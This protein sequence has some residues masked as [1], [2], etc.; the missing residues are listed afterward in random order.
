MKNVV[1]KLQKNK[2][3][4]RKFP[5]QFSKTDRLSDEVPSKNSDA[6]SISGWYV[7]VAIHIR[8]K[9]I[10]LLILAGLCYYHCSN[11]VYRRLLAGVRKMLL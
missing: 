2:L 8:E 9:C 11:Q 3:V 6:C 4:S 1:R 7:I 5:A 10:D